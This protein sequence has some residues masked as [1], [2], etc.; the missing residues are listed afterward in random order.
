MK[1][2]FNLDDDLPQNKTLKL[3]NMII[4]VRFVFEESNKCYPQVFVDKYLC[5]L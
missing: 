2:K 1:T 4:V 3:R 5:K